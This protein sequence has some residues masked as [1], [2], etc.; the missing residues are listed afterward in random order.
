[1]DYKVAGKSQSELLMAV[2]DGMETA[3]RLDNQKINET[4]ACEEINGVWN[5]SP[6]MAFAVN[7]L[8]FKPSQYLNM[9]LFRDQ[10]LHNTF[11][12]LATIM[13]Q[14][15]VNYRSEPEKYKFAILK[16]AREL[17]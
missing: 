4:V 15:D 6:L 2:V 16:I 14:I 1:M 10:P 8:G 7:M 5:L 13:S 12:S 11:M 9:D 3:E 17:R